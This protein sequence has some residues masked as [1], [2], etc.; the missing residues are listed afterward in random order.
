MI[1]NVTVAHII[2][3]IYKH[4][5]NLIEPE[6]QDNFIAGIS[7]QVGDYMFLNQM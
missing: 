1:R 5:L 4:S 7:N 6:F 2:P 3:Q